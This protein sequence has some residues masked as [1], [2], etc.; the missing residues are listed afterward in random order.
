MVATVEQTLNSDRYFGPFWGVGTIDLR[1]DLKPTYQDILT[2]ACELFF[3]RLEP[4]PHTHAGLLARARV[5]IADASGISSAQAARS[6]RMPASEITPAHISHVALRRMK[7]EMVFHLLV[8]H[9]LQP[10][11]KTP[12]FVGSS[13]GSLQV[14]RHAVDPRMVGVTVAIDYG[15]TWASW[16]EWDAVGPFLAEIISSLDDGQIVQ[17]DLGLS[18]V[19]RLLSA[20]HPGITT[21][22]VQGLEGLLELQQPDWSRQDRIDWLTVAIGLQSPKAHDAAS[23][24]GDTRYHPVGHSIDGTTIVRAAD[25]ALYRLTPLRARPLSIAGQGESRPTPKTVTLE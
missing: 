25:G 11:P 6:L 12:F 7:I 9:W 17:T 1:D 15:D 18:A 3:A 14:L 20:M 16:S 21:D 19:L 2:G 4:G 24:V 5:A 8:A 23:Q 13:Q 10:S 22:L